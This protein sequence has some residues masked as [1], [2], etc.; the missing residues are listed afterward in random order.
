MKKLLTV[1]FL[2]L[3]L[4]ACDNE[5]FDIRGNQYELIGTPTN[6]A[7][8]LIFSDTDNR[9]FGKAV[10]NYF[11]TYEIKENKLILSAP[12][13]TMMMGP[14]EA[15]QTEMKYFQDL[16][17][18]HSFKVTEDELIIMLTDGKQ[19]TFK[20]KENEVSQFND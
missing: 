1:L 19:L 3:G 17:Q 20:K 6:S 7:I 5:N 12:A 16:H 9:Y 14:E 15:M 10:N 13:S 2:T 8:T 11:G 18:V 4:C